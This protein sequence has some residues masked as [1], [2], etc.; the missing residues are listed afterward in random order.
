MINNTSRHA[1]YILPLIFTL[2]FQ[3]DYSVSDKK[4]KALFSNSGIT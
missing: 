4:T 2:A 3:K 1:L